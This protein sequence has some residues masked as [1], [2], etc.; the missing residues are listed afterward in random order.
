MGDLRYCFEQDYVVKMLISMKNQD[1]L[2]GEIERERS[3]L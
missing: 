3:F 1:L 2:V